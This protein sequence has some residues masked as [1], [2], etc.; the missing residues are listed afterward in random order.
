MGNVLNSL[1]PQRS[2]SENMIRKYDT[3]FQIVFNLVYSCRKHM[4]IS[5]D[6]HDKCRSN[7]LVQILNKP[8][9][10]ISHDELER[11]DFSLANGIMHSC[12][13]NKVPLPRAITSSSIIHGA[14]DNFD[15]NKNTLTGKG[16]SY[17][18][19][20]WYFKIRKTQ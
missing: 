3:I 14:M 17:D 11:I 5:Q 16:S 15:Y 1:F 19:I 8:G 9:L 6:I 13:E 18:A 12:V 10:C 2:R 7:Q 20:F 4:S